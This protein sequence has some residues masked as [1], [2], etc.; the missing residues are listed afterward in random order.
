MERKSEKSKG[1]YDWEDRITVLPDDLLSMI[2]HPLPIKEAAAATIL[3]NRWKHIW[4]STTNLNYDVTGTFNY[5][6]DRKVIKLARDMS[7]RCEPH[8]NV[9]EKVRKYFMS[10]C[11]ALVNAAHNL[12]NLRVVG[13]LDCLEAFS[14]DKFIKLS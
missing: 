2:V 12:V 10:N 3:S 1:D 7:T 8:I 4:K 6:V 5:D 14:I 11:A 13:P 9:T